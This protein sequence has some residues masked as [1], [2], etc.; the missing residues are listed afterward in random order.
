MQRREKRSFIIILIPGSTLLR[1]EFRLLGPGKIMD[2]VIQLEIVKDER[3]L[4]PV[5]YDLK[6]CCFHRD[7][8]DQEGRKID[9]KEFNVLSFEEAAKI[10]FDDLM[11]NWRELLKKGGYEDLE[12][13]RP[14]PED[15][16]QKAREYLIDLIRHPEKI[17]HVPNK[18]NLDILERLVLKESVNLIIKNKTGKILLESTIKGQTEKRISRKPS[19]EIEIIFEK[20]EIVFLH[21]KVCGNKWKKGLDIHQK[22]D[23]KRDK[24]IWNITCKKCNRTYFSG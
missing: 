10:A 4:T 16:V 17:K 11:N 1:V 6:H 7:I 3:H 24:N 22:F 5:R 19:G 14:L 8:I 13:I 21:C 23:V 12:F 18:V 9:K 15:S 20:G 2:F